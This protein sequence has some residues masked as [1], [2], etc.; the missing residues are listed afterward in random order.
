MSDLKEDIN[1]SISSPPEPIKADEDNTVGTGQTKSHTSRFGGVKRFF[2]FQPAQQKNIPSPDVKIGSAVDGV[3]GFD[4]FLI[5]TGLV[6]K[7]MVIDAVTLRK[8]RGEG[9]KR[10]LFQILI[11]EFNV[12]REQVYE[13][14]ARYYSFKTIDLSNIQM[15][16][17]ILNFINKTLET[18]PSKIREL[19][20]SNKILPFRIAEGDNTKIQLITPDP[21]NTDIATIARAFSFPRHEVCYVSLKNFEELFRQLTVDHQGRPVVKSM[22]FI[23]EDQDVIEELDDEIRRGHLAEIVDAIFAD[24]VRV[25]ASDIH[26]IPR[27]ARK[28]EIHFRVDGHLTVWQ[29]IDDLRA[30]AVSAVIKDVAKGTDRFERNMA[31]DGFVQKTIDNKIVRFR[32]SIIPIVGKD[33]KVKFE[34]IVIRVLQD[35][36]ASITIETMG[37]EPYALDRFRKAIEKPNGII[38]LTGPTGSGKSTTLL[39]ALR[40]VMDPSL[41]IITVED[42]VE[43]FIDGARQV[44]LNPKLDF[45]GALR[46]ILRH[47]PDI[48]MVGEI[49]DKATADMAIKLANTGHLT[50]STLHTNDAP[51]VIARL[52]K[53]GLEPFLLAYAINIIVAQRL[54]R[55]LCTRCK[56][57]DHEILPISLEKVGFPKEE[58]PTAKFYRAAGCIHCLGGYKGRT[59]IHEVLYFTRNIRQLIMEAGSSIN[60][61]AIRQTAIK[62]GMKTL[63]EAGIELLRKGITT[64]EEIAST[65][66]DD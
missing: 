54:V 25:N 64:V 32:V 48:V 53:M 6:S 13:E 56:A 49:R 63:R 28:T 11:E 65:T 30:D 33:L 46:A 59:A 51:S 1:Q 7:Q 23:E 18:L 19:A 27:A 3:S 24:A 66:S 34:S 20:I 35:P 5:R 29:T 8:S 43:Y 57:E 14:F 61:E 10:R 45:E 39:A 50:F 42:P 9:E 16:G 15:D 58:I 31:Q 22:D 60:E 37:F 41:N 38:I 21:T 2:P 47:D 62:E 52:Y 26:I 12:D 17:E 55:K 4:E 36:E 40:A 44:K